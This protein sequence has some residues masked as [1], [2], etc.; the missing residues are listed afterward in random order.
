MIEFSLTDAGNLAIQQQMHSPAVY[1][2]HW[3][4][5][6][7]SEDSALET[8]FVEVLTRKAGTLVIS[9]LNLFEFTKMRDPKTVRAAEKLLEDVIPQ[10]FF[11]ESNPFKV[12]ENEAHLS[13]GYVGSGAPQADTDLLRGLTFLRPAGLKAFTAEGLITFLHEADIGKMIDELSSTV[14]ERIE[15]MRVEMDSSVSVENLIRHRPQNRTF[16]N[17]TAQILQE[18]LRRFLYDRRIN[19]TINDGIDLLHTV[20]PVSYCDFVLL[21]RHWAKEVNRMRQQ[22]QRDHLKLPLAHVFSEPK[23]GIGRFLVQLSEYS[24]I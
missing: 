13:A 20:V 21:D 11:I 9:W 24:D 17:G 19:V 2:D 10:L 15:A 16:V 3:A 7:I 18:L 22:F 6:R 4:M 1:L 12:M 5:R 23:D 14:V 8:R